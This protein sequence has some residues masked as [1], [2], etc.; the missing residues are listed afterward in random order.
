[1]NQLRNLRRYR[2][3][4]LFSDTTQAALSSYVAYEPPFAN[5]PRF[6]ITDTT[7]KREN[8]YASIDKNLNTA[9]T[10]AWLTCRLMLITLIEINKTKTCIDFKMFA[11]IYKI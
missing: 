3:K 2:K 10:T 4:T 6:V 5:K 11:I 8:I 1:M 9:T 7:P